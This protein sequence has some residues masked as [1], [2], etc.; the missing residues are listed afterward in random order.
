MITKTIL[1]KLRGLYN[2]K[3]NSLGFILHI[4]NGTEDHIHILLSI[5]PKLNIAKVLNH[6]KG[7]SSHEIPELYWQKGYSAFT[8]DKTSFDR[9]FN[10]I[11]NQQEHHKTCNFDDEMNVL[12]S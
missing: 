11:R 12:F 7:Y 10:Y 8:L 5:P 6:L 3:A 2:E 1:D 9:I 4:V